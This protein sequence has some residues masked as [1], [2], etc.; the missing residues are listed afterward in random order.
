MELKSS[1]QTAKADK[2]Q[3]P[4]EKQ[5]PPLLIDRTALIAIEL[6]QRGDEVLQD[7]LERLE[8]KKGTLTEIAEAEDSLPDSSEMIRRQHTHKLNPEL[9]K[10]NHPLQQHHGNANLRHH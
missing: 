2:N 3:D 10:D 6:Q 1:E 7:I 4:E 9:L 8:S 5:Q